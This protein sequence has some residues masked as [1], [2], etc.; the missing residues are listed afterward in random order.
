MALK[1]QSPTSLFREGWVFSSGQ[2]KKCTFAAVL[3]GWAFVRETS[4]F[5]KIPESLAD[6]VNHFP[7][8]HCPFSPF[9][10]PFFV[11]SHDI[12]QFFPRK[13]PLTKDGEA[14]NT[15]TETPH[16]VHKLNPICLMI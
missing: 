15:A 14:L 7:I 2:A 16:K 10:P 4:Y 3:R 8:S 5:P 12:T 13:K 9:L 11:S 1:N 6:E